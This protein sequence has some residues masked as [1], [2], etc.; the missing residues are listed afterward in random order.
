[1]D[2]CSVEGIRLILATIAAAMPHTVNVVAF[3]CFLFVVCGIVG[4][5]V[6]HSLIYQAPVCFTD[7]LTTL[8]VQMFR[9]LTRSKCVSYRNEAILQSKMKPFFP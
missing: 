1:M 8:T 5:Q 7:P 3:L 4:V 9:G 6:S 2:C